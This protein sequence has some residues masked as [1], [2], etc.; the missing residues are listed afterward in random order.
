MALKALGKR[1][2]TS[3]TGVSDRTRL[4]VAAVAL[5]AA[6]CLLAVPKPVSGAVLTD[7]TNVLVYNEAETDAFITQLNFGNGILTTTTDPSEVYEGEAAL[8]LTNDQR[9]DSAGVF[10]VLIR[11]NPGVGEYRYFTFAW[12]KVVPTGEGG[13]QIQLQ[14]AGVPG[15]EAWNQRYHAGTPIFDNSIALSATLPLQYQVYTV[16]LWSDFGGDMELIGIGL[17]LQ[18]SGTGHVGLFDKLIFHRFDVEPTFVGSGEVNALLFTATTVDDFVASLDGTTDGTGSTETCGSYVRA[19]HLVA[20]DGEVQTATGLGYVITANPTG[21]NQF[22]YATFAWRKDAPKAVGVPEGGIGIQ[23]KSTSP[24]FPWEQRYHAG[25]VF[26]IYG[27]VFNSIQLSAS[28]P[29]DWEIH[30]VDLFAYALFF[31]FF[32]FFFGR[33]CG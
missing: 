32:V 30:T 23:F 11:E 27:G 25:D 14:K 17:A 5:A 4:V 1:R 18:N 29:G 9:F 20:T 2:G 28:T 7:N 33:L 21:T 3:R 12:R 24:S 6:V 15:P 13:I 22:R 8:K 19:A 26:D 10:S 31:V 16:D